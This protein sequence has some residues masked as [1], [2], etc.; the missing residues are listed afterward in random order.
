MPYFA[1]LFMVF[2][3]G[4]V[5]LP[6]TSGFVGEML[7]IVGAYQAASWAA[8]GAATGLILG[9]AYMLWLYRRVMLGDITH[10][11]VRA[12]TD[13]NT[14]EW[15]YF[16]PMVVAVLWLGIHPISMTRSVAPAVTQL[17]HAM[18]RPATNAPQAKRRARAARRTARR[19]QIRR[20]AGQGRQAMNF[21]PQSLSLLM[22][23][24]IVAGGAL[25][26]LLYGAFRGRAPPAGSRCSP[27]SSW[28][29]PPGRCSRSIST[30][31]WAS[32]TSSSSTISRSS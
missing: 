3:M 8:I 18:Q 31:R 16:I 10:G 32:P 22:P 24:L 11:E 13:V 19:C 29:S 17:V 20:R 2:T 9:A 7:V 30:W 4:S 6:A 21:D 26:L 1:A 23:E 14:R 28:A 5:G 12:L 25:L 15:L 27:S